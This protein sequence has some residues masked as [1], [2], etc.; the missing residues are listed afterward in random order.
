MKR[1]APEPV[2]E[3]SAGH[4]RALSNVGGKVETLGDPG[5]A[6]RLATALAV[7]PDPEQAR[8]H[9]HGFHSYPARMHPTTARRLVELFA[10]QRG[11]VL[12]PFCGSGTV[13]VEAR[14][15]GRAS[16]GMDVNPIA[17][18]LA[19]L[20]VS[21][22]TR[23]QTEA[24]VAAARQIGMQGEARRKARAGATRRYPEVDA[25]QF[26]PHVLLELDSIRDGIARGRPGF[27]TDTLW[28]VLS[29]I[30]TKVSRKR[31]D[32]GELEEQARR[33]AAGYTLRLFF[34]KTEELAERLAQFTALAGRSAPR[35]RVLCGDARELSGVEPASVDVLISSPPYPGNYDYLAHHETRLRWLGK[36]SDGLEAAEI[37]SRRKLDR[38][39][40]AAARA[41]FARDMSRVLQATHRVVRREAVVLLV[42]ADS[43]AAGRAV[44]ADALMISC[45]KQEGFRWL[46]TAS[47]RRPHFHRG[48][49]RAFEREE[50]REHLIALQA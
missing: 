47:Q 2:G 25:Q 19:E 29:S 18:A 13:L 9:M 15:A 39:G 50:R 46:A 4:R 6:A 7:E 45:A 5:V 24:L 36:K 10:P 31:G 44:R 32:T 34:R 49:E 26:E 1:R 17:A 14:L 35:A 42:M 37:G 30:L 22:A 23:E 28:L 12:D 40:S 27:V 41:A 21:G 8:A 38:I 20:K 33:L 3:R 48:S 16:I 11:V 43:V